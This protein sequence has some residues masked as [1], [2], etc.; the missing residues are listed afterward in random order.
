MA[1]RGTGVLGVFADQD[2]ARR[3]AEAAKRAGANPSGI[4]VGDPNDR[5]TALRA[6]MLDEVENTI[7]APGNVGPFTREQAKAIV[8]LTF[9]LGAIGVLIAVPFAFIE[10]FGLAFWARLLIL[11]VVGGAVGS[12]V[13]FQIGGM[14]GARRPEERLPPEE[15][16][17]LAID[18]AP[19]R[20]IDVLKS[21][22]P[23][24][25]DAVADGRVLGP[26]EFTD[27]AERHGG[28]VE[29]VKEHMRDR[30][31]EGG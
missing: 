12:V 29:E 8:P 11:A 19:E 5:V 10:F 1:Q 30:D 20:A 2:A 18:D 15:G 7:M 24:Q 6:D 31:L 3:A 22:R 21:M 16:V 9:I 28:L 13:G 25:L 26:I 17:T 27:D 23:L 14:Y 4:R